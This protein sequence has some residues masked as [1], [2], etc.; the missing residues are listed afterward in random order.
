[1]KAKKSYRL[2]I[3][4]ISGTSADGIDAALVK[5][6]GAYPKIELDFLCG[7]TLPYP[8]KVKESIFKLSEKGGKARE[9]SALNFL[10]GK[11][12]ARA[13]LK[14][15]KTV[16]VSPKRVSLIASHGQ[17]VS[18]TPEGFEIAGRKTAATWQLGEISLIEQR[19]RIPTIG[20]FRTADLSV[21]G[22][23]ALG[24]CG[25]AGSGHGGPG[26]QH[27]RDGEHARQHRERKARSV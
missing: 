10:L 22:Q 23:G 15:L 16:K 11:F 3:G 6:T 13:A 5:I 25:A 27:G 19:T 2:V 1:M 26:H 14:L 12:F 7:L 18:H 9:F 21:G 24:R 4:L 8:A 17:T 20:D